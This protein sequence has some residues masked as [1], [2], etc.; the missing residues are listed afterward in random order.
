MDSVYIQPAIDNR[1]LHQS[2]RWQSFMNVTWSFCIYENTS[3]DTPP[4]GENQLPEKLHLSRFTFDPTQFY[5]GI[6]HWEG[7]TQSYSI[8]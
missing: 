4:S 7:E 8:C 1:T 5:Y 6:L 3:F 2:H